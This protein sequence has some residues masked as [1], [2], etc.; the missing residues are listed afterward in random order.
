MTIRVKVK[1][2]CHGS[3]STID[4]DC[5]WLCYFMFQGKGEGGAESFSLMVRVLYSLLP[6]TPTILPLM[7]SIDCGQATNH[8]TIA[9]NWPHYSPLHLSSGNCVECTKTLK[10]DFLS[11]DFDFFNLL[12]K[13]TL[14]ISLPFFTVHPSRLRYLFPGGAID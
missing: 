2:H 10:S 13:L 3:A 8:G 5:M 12:T 6:D 11:A 1:L 9:P 4:M 7:S 14:S